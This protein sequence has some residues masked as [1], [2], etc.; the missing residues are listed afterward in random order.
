MTSPRRPL[1]VVITGSECTGKT[2]LAA[3]L[4]DL[5]NAPWSREFVRE[6]VD[7]KQAPLDA[8]D[9]DPIA[10]GQ[11]AGEQAGEQEAAVRGCRVVIRDTDLHSTVVYSRHYYGEC[12]GWVAEA[13]HART[14]DL[15][16]LLAPDV[17]WVADGLQRDRPDDQNRARIHELFRSA[18]TAGAARVVEI[19]GDWPERR[20][21]AVAEVEALIASGGPPSAAR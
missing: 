19:R 1:T 9:V 12:P 6:Y 10:L 4:A 14:G 17:P 5:V 15:Y 20:A 8:S 3:E 13:A 18:L 2:T 16:L 21:Q 11:L 7:R